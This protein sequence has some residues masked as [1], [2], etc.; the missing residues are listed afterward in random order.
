M[1]RTDFRGGVEDM[2]FARV[3]VVTLLVGLFSLGVLTGCGKA[4]SP[5]QP[6][7]QTKGPGDYKIVLI[8]PGPIN[9]Q[10]WNATNYSGLTACKDRKSVM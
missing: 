9:D 6:T 2:K 3:A 4:S 1:R 8:L 10:S 5:Q 7:S